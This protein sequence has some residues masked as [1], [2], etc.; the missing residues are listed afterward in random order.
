MNKI[1]NLS[2]LND[3]MAIYGKSPQNKIHSP[4]PA[5]YTRACSL[6]DKSALLKLICK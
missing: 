5:M 6:Q 3:H 4:F 2:M 1:G